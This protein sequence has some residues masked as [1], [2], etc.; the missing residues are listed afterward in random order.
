MKKYNYILIVTILITLFMGYVATAHETSSSDKTE[1]NKQESLFKPLIAD[2][3]WPH[4]SVSYQQY[5]D[6]KEL[7]NI[8]ST[9][10]GETFTSHPWN[11]FNGKLNIGIQG[12]VFAFFNLDAESMDLINADYWIGFPLQYKQ[13]KFSAIFRLF[14]QSSHLGDEYL[15]NN[16]IDRVNLSYESVDLKISYDN[17]YNVLRFYTGAG[18]IFHK[19]PEDIKPVSAQFG[20]EYKCNKTFLNGHIRPIA[21]IDT[22]TWEENDWGLDM[23]IRFGAQLENFES[24]GRKLQLMFEYFHGN[25]PHGQFYN[26]KIK[27]TG[28]GTHF[29][30]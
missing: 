9:S 22:K 17:I 18:Y 12:A 6:D 15:L 16:D 14:H 27:Y 28:I 19:E 20:A 10:F 30:F 25:S 2:P 3:R 21:G 11:T 8:A 26:R 13:D 7:K 23:S 24:T 5:I 1:D 4:F 29:Y